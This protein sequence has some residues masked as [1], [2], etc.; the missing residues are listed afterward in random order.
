MEN[1]QTKT[2]TKNKNIFDRLNIPRERG[3]FL[4][5]KCSE[6]FADWLTNRENK[7]DIVDLLWA[8]R[9]FCTNAAEDMLMCY[10]VGACYTKMINDMKTP[11]SLL[12]ALESIFGKK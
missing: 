8:G 6:M 2:E 10:F 5:N 1:T 11:T 4:A 12:N 7:R 3:D 9:E